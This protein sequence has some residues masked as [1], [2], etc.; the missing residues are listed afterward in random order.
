MSDPQPK[1]GEHGG[2][3][4]RV[5]AVL[6]VVVLVGS[7][8][9]ARASTRT[10]ANPA[11]IS[12]EVSAA[13]QTRTSTA[14][15]VYLRERADLTGA[16]RL[17][18]SDARAT[19]VHRRLTDTASR[20]QRA[21]LAELTGR[22]ARHT[23]YWISN[24]VRVEGDR[25][26]VDAIAARPEVERIVASRSY[27]LVRP[28]PAKPVARS[29]TAAAEWGL[30]S[31]EAPRVWT[32][33]GV[34]GADVVV[35]NIDT[36]VDYAHPALVGKYRGNLGNGNFDH[37]YN[38][39]DPAAVCPDAAPCDNDGHGSH[40][41]GTMVGDDGPENQI[42]VAPGAKWIAAKGCESSSCS[43]TSLLAAGQWVL[44]PT[45]G[46]GKNPRPDLHADI[47]NNSWGGGS[48]DRWYADTVDAWRAVGIFP[49]FSTGNSGPDCGTAGSPG[50]YPGS[51]AAGSYAADNTISDFSSR[52]ASAVDGGIKPNIAAPGQ[53]IRSST[54][55]NT[56]AWFSGTSMATP[57]V[58]G[59][60]ALIW[61]AAPALRGD[62]AATEE[63]LDSTAT[64]VDA[65]ECGGTV[66]DNNTFGEGRLNAYQAVK[67]APRGPVGQL[68]GTVT[69]AAGGAPIADATVSV[70]G[71]SYRTG[72]DGRY[73][74][75]LPAGQH[76]VTAAAYGFVARTETVTVP[77]DGSV[78]RDFALVAAPIVTVTGRV[79]DG[80]GHRWPLYAAIAVPDR[81]G[82]PIF[83][84]PVTGQFSFTVPGST[85]YQVTTTVQYPGYPP[86]TTELKLGEA[87]RTANIAVPVGADCTAPGYRSAAGGGCA[88]VPGGLVVGN[89]FDH[90][91]GTALNAV[92]VVR[93]DW[94]A[95]HPYGLS[96]ATPDDP[97]QPDGFY[98]LFSDRVG[99]LQFRASRAAYATAGAA[100]TVVAD[101]VSRA[102]FALRAGR[103]TVTP[104]SVEIHQPYGS[105]RTAT[106]TVRNTG[107]AP[108][109]VEL[110]ERPGT[111][112][113]LSRPGA[114]P[115]E[116]HLTGVSTASRTTRSGGPVAP[117][118]ATRAAPAAAESWQ[119]I[120]DLPTASFDHS[121][122]VWAGKV[123]SIGGGIGTGTA[124]RATVYDPATNAWSGLPDLP[125]G[126][127]KPSVTVAGD[128]VYVIGG[129]EDDD[130]WD[131]P[132]L[133]DVVAYDLATGGAW[134]QLPGVT[135]PAPRAG[136]GTAV[137]DGKLYLVGGCVDAA[138]GKSADL[139][140]F[141]PATHEFRTGADYPR[142]TSWVSCGGIGGRVYCAGG[143]ADEPGNEAYVYDPATDAWTPLPAP[144]VALW[145]SQYA[146]AGGLLVINGGI[147]ADQDVIT[148]RTIA[149]DPVQGG[150]RDLPVSQFAQ[151][152]GAG[153]CGAYKLGGM[154]EPWTPSAESELLG[155]L[156]SCHE[157]LDVPWLALTPGVFT[158]APGES[159]TVTVSL[160]A[161]SAAGID[162]P[163][164]YAATVGIRADIPYPTPTVAVRTNVAPP[165]SWGKLQ[166]TV[167][168]KPC[169]GDPVPVSATVQINLA[170]DPGTGYT[171]SAD[172]QGR[173]AIW[174]PRSRYDMIVARDGWKPQGRRVAVSAG[175]VSTVDF[176]LDP[177]RTCG[178]RFGGL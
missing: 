14:F 95:G 75:A 125:V 76:R 10:R 85:T 44:A 171:L 148:N 160:T 20:T 18:G 92:R 42:G 31:I 98:H 178:S 138:C 82:G 105:T 64:D 120:A 46:N 47:V 131:A 33:L 60:V 163:G 70:A 124:R 63:L 15:L 158:L 162:Q 103:L 53:E 119:R 150:W 117:M 108:T 74:F 17:G 157:T 79:G 121:A 112:D 100:V 127:G 57:H 67:A 41:M 8:Q 16:A 91:T 77:A 40:T 149:Y 96:A 24:A 3:L 147:H 58:A 37:D 122:A 126:R 27:E 143:S 51:Y 174:L 113:L 29:G 22:K 175:L 107:T 139:V 34:R 161:T 170:N 156:E 129:W 30:T 173:Y 26:L 90:N 72:P 12:P 130:D 19:E 23:A 134:Q 13:L 43:D 65:V 7:A 146:A 104:G 61:S 152:R 56:Y 38:W 164:A 167:L 62:L 176:T 54:P 116:R 4:W 55:D 35:A 159:R 136:A 68:R 101:G 94:V 71:R 25:A 142:A 145:G 83:T 86:V 93:A 151:Y 84:D 81:P 118:A 154:P 135:N 80:S 5:L 52:G 102:D 114:A 110:L 106:V 28:E 9:P 59:T 48:G 97:N 166:G 111:F 36:G 172:D 140:I 11:P 2:R 133:A 109:E 99:S 177:V 39:Y 45:D 50:D 73:A 128:K 69:A 88:P 155:G 21:L 1:P 123:Y 168:G 141:D 32:E 153:A 165:P 144:P 49:S 87:G 169:T 115:V 66:A 132:P 137:A 89:T 6:L 78:T